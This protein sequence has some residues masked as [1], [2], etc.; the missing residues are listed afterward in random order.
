MPQYECI[1]SLDET[2][3]SVLGKDQLYLLNHFT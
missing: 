3:S 1:V 2:G